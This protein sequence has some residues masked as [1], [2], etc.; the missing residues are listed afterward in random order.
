MILIARAA[1]D[2]RNVR[3]RAALNRHAHDFLIGF[4]DAVADG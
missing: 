2:K 4:D 1:G 3:L